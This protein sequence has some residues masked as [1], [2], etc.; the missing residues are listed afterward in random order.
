MKA[1]IIPEKMKG[2]D[3]V[4]GDLFS[5]AVYGQAYWRGA[6]DGASIGEKV[7][8]RTNVP[9]DMVPD[10][11]QEVWRLTIVRDENG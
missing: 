5:H 8:V 4:P 2:R 11:D 10:P 6:L 1:R 9:L 7:Y 3:L